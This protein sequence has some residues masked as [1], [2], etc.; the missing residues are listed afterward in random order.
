MTVPR[1]MLPAG[2]GRATAKSLDEKGPTTVKKDYQTT[3]ATE[4]TADEI[5]MPEAVTVAMAELTGAVNEGLLALAVGAGVG[6]RGVR[7]WNS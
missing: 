4:A 6:C 5:V 2:R 1:S 3:A 7:W